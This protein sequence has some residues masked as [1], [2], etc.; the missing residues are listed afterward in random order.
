MTDIIQPLPPVDD[1]DAPV[2]PPGK[3]LPAH[4]GE[5]LILPIEDLLAHPQGPGIPRA[6]RVF[7]NHDLRMSAITH[8]GFD[9]DYTLAIYDQPEMDRLS[10]EATTTKLVAR[11]YP[12]LLVDI[13]QATDFAV[14]GLLIDKRFGHIL[15]MDRNK[16]VTKG[17]HGFRE[18]SKDELRSL[19]HAKKARP[20]TARY[21]WIDTLYALSEASL[22][23]ALIDALEKLGHAIDYSKVFADIRESIDEAHRDG[24]ILNAVM[25]DL[26]RFV[27][28]DAD[29]APTLHKLRS[30]GK[31]LFV[32][33]NSR[34]EYTDRMMTYLLGDA[35]AEYPSWKNYFDVVV[36]AATKPAFFQEKRPLLEREGDK[37]KPASL[38]DR[39]KPRKPGTS[40]TVPIYEGGNLVDFERVLGVSGDQVLYVGDHIYG[41][42]LRS[43]KDS[44]WSTAMI[45]QELETEVLAYEAC[46]QDFAQAQQYEDMREHLEND[47]RFYQARFKDLTRAIEHGDAAQSGKHAVMTAAEAEAKIS[48]S[49]VHTLSP[50]DLEAERGRVKRALERIR[51]LLKQVEAELTVLRDRIDQRFHPYWGSLL[52]EA[53]EESIFGAQV[54]EYASL[55]TSRV[56]N[57]LAYSP[58]QFFR[59]PRDVMPHEVGA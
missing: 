41:D 27:K 57:F 11:G 47:L 55:Y 40:R 1:D 43:R 30:S 52:K 28:R 19:Y 46:Q 22:Y 8:V 29:L 12:E 35:M 17:F 10:I 58:Q 15:K 48:Q 20:A 44:A 7:V 13:P 49:G 45:M 39:N 26:P 34:Y 53:N 51:G 9:M 50:S 24:T 32:L 56:S 31:K 59:S 23:A 36:V 25:A 4:V 21:H 16:H 14:R 18:L 5:Q 37:V 6:R 42:I 3:N 33:T 54:E 38:A 2:A